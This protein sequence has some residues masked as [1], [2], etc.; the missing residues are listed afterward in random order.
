MKNVWKEFFRLKR[1]EITEFFR[2]GDHKACLMVVYIIGALAV[3]VY[4]MFWYIN[5]W[6][7][8][9]YLIPIW[10]GVAI[11]IVGIPI[12]IVYC[13]FIIPVKWLCSNWQQAKENVK[14]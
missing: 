13:V 4:A 2:F 8:T 1:E 6:L 7:F 12:G 10:I 14:K 5:V 11:V 9:I 3:L